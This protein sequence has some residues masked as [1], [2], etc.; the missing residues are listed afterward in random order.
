MV[1][2]VKAPLFDEILLA[3]AGKLAATLIAQFI[4]V[5]VQVTLLRVA[6]AV[7]ILQERQ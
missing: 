3:L 5:G 1:A 4:V 7:V 2:L 6:Q